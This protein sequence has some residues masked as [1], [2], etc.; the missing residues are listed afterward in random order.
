MSRPLPGRAE[1]SRNLFLSACL[2]VGALLCTVSLVSSAQTTDNAQANQPAQVSNP[3]QSNQA[4]A[5][6]PAQE[7]KE[8]AALAAAKASARHFD[9][10]VIVVLENGDYEA[11][12]QDKSLAALAAKGASL[13]NF[14]ALFHPSYP[15]YLAMVAGTDFGIHRRGRY[16][17][18]RQVNFPNDAAHKTIAD[19]LIAAGLDFKNYAEELPQGPCPFRIDNQHAA[20]RKT[21]DYVRRHVPFLSL[22]EVQEKWCDRVVAVDSTKGNSLLGLDDNAFVRDA[23]AGLVAYSFYTPNMNNDGHNTNVGVAGAWVARFLDKTFTEKLRKGTLVIVTFDE[24][25][26]NSDN[27]IYTLFLGDMVK[28]ASQQDPKVLDRHYTHYNVLRTIEDNFGLEPLNE[29]DRD[30]APITDIWK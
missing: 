12:V 7:K 14:H 8:D 4:E 24:S 9:R 13:S 17:A 3:A 16:L 29:G 28:E 1:V 11:A 10:V 18:D 30:A 25:D 19:R 5:A 6:R 20:Q 15:N 2:A 26:R 21:G 23:K 22:V 27:R